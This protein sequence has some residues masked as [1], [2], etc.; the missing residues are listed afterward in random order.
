MNKLI[1]FAVLCV[2]F[3]SLC[4]GK[5][6]KE[7]EFVLDLDD[8]R[9]CKTKCLNAKNSK[10]ITEALLDVLDNCSNSLQCLRDLL[11]IDY[12]F[13]FVTYVNFADNIKEHDFGYGGFFKLQQYVYEFQLCK[14]ECKVFYELKQALIKRTAAG[15]TVDKIENA[16][17]SLTCVIESP[18]LLVFSVVEPRLLA[19]IQSGGVSG[20]EINSQTLVIDDYM[21]IEDYH[22]L[23]AVFDAD[24]L[25][26]PYDTKSDF[27]GLTGTFSNAIAPNT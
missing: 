8:T 19:C 25:I 22:G 3:A 18:S 5:P 21:N 10:K 7:L 24:T 16:D 27:R 15:V 20:F 2:A 11:V 1:V 26:V 23:K 17:G 4:L 12:M 13:S 14:K 9:C 6:K